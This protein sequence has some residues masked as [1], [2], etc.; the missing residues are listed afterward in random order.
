[1]TGCPEIVLA[2]EKGICY[3]SLCIVCNMAAGLQ[4]KLD[5]DEISN[6]YSEKKS[7]ISKIFQ[8]TIDAIEERKDCNCNS[9]LS[10]ATL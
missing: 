4:Y 3:A 8:L 10:K 7:I 5:L 2:R 1:M 9:D 6:I